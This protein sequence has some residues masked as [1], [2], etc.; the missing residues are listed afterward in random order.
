MRGFHTLRHSVASILASKGV[1]QR[2]IDK[3]IG[4]HTEAMRQRYQHLFP[5]GV[6]QAIEQLL[7]GQAR[8]ASPGHRHSRP[9][10]SITTTGRATIVGLDVGSIPPVPIP[11]NHAG[12]RWHAQQYRLHW[13]S[14]IS[15]PRDDA[16]MPRYFV[17]ISQTGAVKYG[18]VPGSI[19]VLEALDQYMPIGEAACRT[20]DAK[21][22]AVWT[23]R[24]CK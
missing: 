15:H 11:M 8:P 1:D 16:A 10:L 22:L 4:H 14:S 7:W 13:V 23:L 12:T 24:I 2:Y 5:K 20:W 9:R 3:I 17:L 19:G 21:G 18:Q 6:K